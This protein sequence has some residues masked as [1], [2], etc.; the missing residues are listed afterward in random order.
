MKRK[1]LFIVLLM[2]LAGLSAAQD[3]NDTLSISFKDLPLEIVLDSISFKT[4][5]FFSYDADAIPNGSLFVLKKDNIHVDELLNIL[6]VGTNL[7]FK[8]DDDQIIISRMP[9]TR[10]YNPGVGTVQISG[11]VREFQTKDPI[12]GVN[13]FLNGTTVGTVTDEHGNYNISGISEGNYELV[14]SHVGYQ[15]ASYSFHAEEHSHMTINGLLDYKINTLQQVEVVSDPYVE[16]DDW[17]KYFKVFKREFL[18]T[19]SNS[20]RCDIQNPEVLDF[21]VNGNTGILKAEASEPL[22]II[23]EATGYK[24]SYELQFFEKDYD[25]TSYYGKALFTPLEIEN[26]KEWKKW[27]KN[28][29]KTYRGSIFHFCKALTSNKL[30][31]EGFRMYRLVD[32]AD[33]GRKLP[34][35]SRSNVLRPSRVKYEWKLDFND[36]LMVT[37]EKELESLQYLSYLASNDVVIHGL[38]PNNK[39]DSQK[40]SAQKSILQLKRRFVTLDNHGQIKEPLGLT[41]IGYWSWERVADLMPVDYDP[42]NDKL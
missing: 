8:R 10:T 33:A 23:N 18:G 31:E 15:L 41:T 17:P 38:T 3:T 36:Y 27:K 2:G 39:P 32:L 29:L 35:L 19:S 14:F 28:R 13:V 25:Q 4:G 1:L 7:R 16:T 24:I 20:V 6:L 5:Y 9:G 40:P 37:Y 26:A 11:W 30:Q 34:Q 21:S 12:D 42:K 22:I